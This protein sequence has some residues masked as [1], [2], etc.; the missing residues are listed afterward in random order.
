M[1]I[2]W[3]QYEKPVLLIVTEIK[4]I[5]GMITLVRDNLM[6][7]KQ[8]VQVMAHISFTGKVRSLGSYSFHSS[9]CHRSLGY[10][11]M[12]PRVIGIFRSNGNLGKG[13]SKSK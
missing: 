10:G 2:V 8:T 6:E 7:D 12:S 5:R 9:R 1:G 13:L 11:R 3:V 4:R